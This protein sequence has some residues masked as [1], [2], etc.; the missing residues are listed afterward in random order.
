MKKSILMIFLPLFFLMAT[1]IG[2]A[3]TLSSDGKS[4]TK[5][6]AKDIGPNGF[7][8]SKSGVYEL[9]DDLQF[10]PVAPAVGQVTA[11]ITVNADN[12][13][14]RGNHRTLK[15]IGAGKNSI[16]INIQSRKNIT[17]QNLNLQGR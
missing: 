11:A 6:T 12:V 13:V 1:E 7:K 14:I 16:G 8:I 17:V 15:Q 10:N 9:T 5:I 3:K 4:Y 2:V